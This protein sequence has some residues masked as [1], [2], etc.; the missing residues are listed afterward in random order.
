MSQLRPLQLQR[1]LQPL[2]RRLDVVPLLDML[3]LALLTLMLGSPFVL[4]PGLSVGLEEG[5]Q[6]PASRGR[7]LSGLPAVAVL[8]VRGPDSLLYRGRFLTL[9]ELE[10]LEPGTLAMPDEGTVLLVRAHRQVTLDTLYRVADWA[11]A[12]GFTQLQLAGRGETVADP[13]SANPE[14]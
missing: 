14:P 1:A 11:R 3:L 6:L 9:S 7:P 8:T 4:A 12:E 2:D 10:A 5:F 13:F